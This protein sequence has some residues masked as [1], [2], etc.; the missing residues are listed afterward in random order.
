VPKSLG[1]LTSLEALDLSGNNFVILPKNISELYELQH[2]GL[3]YCRRLRLLQKLPPQLAKLDA[4][5]CT[6][7]STVPSSST[8]VDGNIFEFIFTNC[9]KLYE[10]ACNNIMAY[11]LLKIQLYAKRL[12]SEVSLSLSLS[13]SLSISLSLTHTH[14]LIQS[15]LIISSRVL[16]DV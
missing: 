1:C 15:S 16:M 13:L 4:H 6:S 10:T 12:Y 5:R 3:R 11:A 2:L 7:L 8:I 14:T 9:L